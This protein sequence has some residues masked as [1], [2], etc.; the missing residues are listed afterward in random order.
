MTG[1]DPSTAA[2]AEPVE[3]VDA[4]GRVVRVVTR[5]E[6][7]AGRLRHRCT[8]VAV[9]DGRGRLLVHQRAPWKD[10]WPGRWDLAFGG[11][12]APGE[13][14][15]QAARRELAEEAGIT[16]A[17]TEIGS[18]TYDDDAVSVL[19]RVFRADHD[20]P[21]HCVDGEVVAVDRVPLRGLTAWLDHHE[22]CPDTVALVVPA[23]GAAV[24]SVG[25]GR[26]P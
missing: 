4:E 17:V 16:A 1:P 26:R 6:M 3:E 8:Y 10:V 21:V 14:W 11:V 23:L 18:G 13:D 24:A 5:A 15:E 25:G 20:G 22:V 2:A 7:R 19:G 9:V 12:V